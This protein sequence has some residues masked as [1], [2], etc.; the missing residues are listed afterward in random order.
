MLRRT[1][2][3]GSARYALTDRFGGV[4]RPPY[5]ALDLGDHVG[6][7]PAAVSENRR[8]LA[9]GVGL[10]PAALVF[11]QQVHGAGVAVEYGERQKR[12]SED[13]DNDNAD[14]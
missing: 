5:D 8:L 14:E 7:D 1:G 2:T 4:S 11:M 10:D 13:D 12:R 9:L 3:I 6:D